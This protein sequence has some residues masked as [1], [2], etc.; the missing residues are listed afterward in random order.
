MSGVQVHEGYVTGDPADSGSEDL[1][2]GGIAGKIDSKSLED[3]C[4]FVGEVVNTNGVNTGGFVGYIADLPAILR[5]GVESYVANKSGKSYTGGFVGNHGGGLI[6]DSSAQSSVDS[7]EGDDGRRG[8]NVGGFAGGVSKAARIATSWCYSHVS[9]D[10]GHY[11]G[12]FVGLASSGLVTGS[13]YEDIENGL[14]AAGTSSGSDDYDGITPLGDEEMRRKESFEALDFVD[15]WKIDEETYPYLR[16]L[17]SA[18]ELWLKDVGITDELAPEDMPKPEDMVEGIP[19][20]VRY[21]FGIDPSIGPADLTEPLIDIMFNTDGKPYVKLPTIVNTEGAT[22]TV[23]ATEDLAD[24]T[25]ATK[26]QVDPATGICA[27]DFDP[28]PPKMFFKYSIDVDD[29]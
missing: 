7:T 13:Y 15:V 24:W 27:P 12:A 11:R 2:V 29:N 14:K 17:F 3:G 10:G 23:L 16:T 4:S 28:V 26:Y 21:V 18:Y 1:G 20:G 9:S 25:R 19:A 22:V 6:A 8:D 5:C